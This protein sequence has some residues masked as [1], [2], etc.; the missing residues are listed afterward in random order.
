MDGINVTADGL[1]ISGIG[2]ISVSDGVLS[3]VG[4]IDSL[5]VDNLKVEAIG[6]LNG[7]FDLSGEFDLSAVGLVSLTIENNS[8]NFSTLDTGDVSVAITDFYLNY[9]DSMI[10]SAD[11][12]TIDATGLVLLQITFSQTSTLNVQLTADGS[13]SIENMDVMFGGITINLGTFSFICSD[14]RSKCL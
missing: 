5:I 11:S 8:M 9:N 4:A 7:T 12:I 13:V 3:A 2:S 1:S 6:L 14:C 10:I